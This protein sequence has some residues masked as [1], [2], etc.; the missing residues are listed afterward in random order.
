MKPHAP[1]AFREEG[2]ALSVPSDG[3]FRLAVVADTHGRPHPAT[4]ERLAALAPTAILHAGDVGPLTVLDGLAAIAPVVAVQGNA[5][6]RT[7]RLPDAVVVSLER[8]DAVVL[9]I[10]L[11]HVGVRITRLHDDVRRRAAAADASLVV[12][13]HSHV[14]LLSRDGRIVVFNPGSCGPPRRPLPIVFGVIEVRRD[15]VS[16]AHVDC[17]TGARW[18]PP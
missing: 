15:G 11:T 16:L 5:D 3:L 12:C 8:E 18:T 13:G 6:D 4:H 2:R 14:P 17:E 10:Y 1:S 7:G 9:R